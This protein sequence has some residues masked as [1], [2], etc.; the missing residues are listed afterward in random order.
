MTLVLASNFGAGIA[1]MTSDTR[2]VFKGYWLDT[3]SGTYSE[4]EDAA[5]RVSEEKQIKTNFLTDYVLM[6][7]AGISDLC[8]HFQSEMNKL[9][10]KDNDLEECHEILTTLIKDCRSKTGSNP[11]FSFLNQENE[12]MIILNGFKRNGQSGLVIFN[13]G[14][15]TE[16]EMLETPKEGSRWTMTAAEKHWALGPQLIDVSL[17]DPS[18]MLNKTLTVHAMIA[19]KEQQTISPECHCYVLFYLENGE[20]TTFK[21]EFDTSVWFEALAEQEAVQK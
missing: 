12:M 15:E 2:E 10:R 21:Y 4:D 5:Y 18:S 13:A 20:T 16:V 11:V 19:A 9:I 6:G 3:E 17:D 1:V 14:P 7:T 8:R